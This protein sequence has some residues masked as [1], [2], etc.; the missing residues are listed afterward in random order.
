[1]VVLLLALASAVL[2]VAGVLVL[3]TRSSGDDLFFDVY[4]ILVGTVMGVM[5]LLAYWATHWGT[6]GFGAVFIA[7]IL[8]DGILYP[9]LLDFEPDHGLD[10]K[11]LNAASLVV[12]MVISG[13]LI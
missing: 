2:A 7:N 5:P 12:L 3:A 13:V 6:L 4:A 9:P 8:I 11:L 1:M 10:A